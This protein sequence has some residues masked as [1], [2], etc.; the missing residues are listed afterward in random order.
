MTLLTI[1]LSVLS[2]KVSNALKI[3]RLFIHFADDPMLIGCCHHAFSFY[4][5]IKN[6]LNSTESKD[7]CLVVLLF[8]NFGAF[9]KFYYKDL[10]IN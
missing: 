5:L 8:D 7:S 1:D 10:L 9:L 2:N 6:F 4:D 3:A